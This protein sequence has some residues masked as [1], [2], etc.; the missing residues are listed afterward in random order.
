TRIPVSRNWRINPR[1]Q[2]DIRK[3][4]DGRTQN[5]L[6]AL[7]R[8]DYRYL[9][10]VRF[11]FELGY[12]DTDDVMNGQSLGTNNLFFMMGYRWDF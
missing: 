12:D 6:R 7:I 5:K 8:T 11:D 4:T 3:S 1:L 10:R 9:N 2:Y